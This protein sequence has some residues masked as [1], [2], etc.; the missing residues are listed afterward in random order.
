MCVLID[1]LDF[2]SLNNKCTL[3]WMM[4]W[5]YFSPHILIGFSSNEITEGWFLANIY[6]DMDRNP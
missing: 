3:K 1:K 6:Q 4:Y 5:Y 2:I